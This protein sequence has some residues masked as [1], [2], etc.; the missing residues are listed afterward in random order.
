MKSHKS[1][2]LVA[3]MVSALVLGGDAFAQTVAAPGAD[4]YQKAGSAIG[5]G[6]AV[7]G[8]AMAQGNAARGFYESVA[9]NPQAAGAINAAFFVG[10]ALIESLGLL[11]FLVAAGL[12]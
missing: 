5:L 12:I 9:R 7:F 3:V 11:A 6:L 10:M 1:K 4:A 2:I 8:G